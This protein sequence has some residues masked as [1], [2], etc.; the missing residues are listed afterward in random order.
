M[1]KQLK[2]GV[3]VTI[4]PNGHVIVSNSKTLTLCNSPI[5]G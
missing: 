4:T 1:T 5:N 3:E 2:T